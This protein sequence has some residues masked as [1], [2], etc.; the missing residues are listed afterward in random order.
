MEDD[1]AD[2]AA[3]AEDTRRTIRI[4]SAASVYRLRGV[5]VGVF[6]V[7]VV[8][9]VAIVCVCFLFVM[10]RVWAFYAPLR[11]PLILIYKRYFVAGTEQDGRR[12]T[13]SQKLNKERHKIKRVHTK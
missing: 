13:K 12:P 2:E 8:A 9:A 3:A 7:V 4:S 10:Y 5:V 11:C 1:E 6:A